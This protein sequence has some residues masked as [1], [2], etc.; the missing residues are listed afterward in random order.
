MSTK[1]PIR[2]HTN[3]WHDAFEIVSFLVSSSTLLISR[4]RLKVDTQFLWKMN[5]KSYAH[6]G[7][8]TLLMTLID[9]NTQN[10]P[11]FYVLSH[12]SYS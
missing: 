11:N 9:P 5:N 8:V 6:Y 10:I 4:E 2:L 1:D 7:K 12:P 3:S